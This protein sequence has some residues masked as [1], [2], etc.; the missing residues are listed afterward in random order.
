MIIHYWHV[1]PFSIIL[2][3]FWVLNAT[4]STA[5]KPRDTQDKAMY[6][7]RL[8]H[9]QKTE[10][11]T[12][13]FV[14][15]VQYRLLHSMTRLKHPLPTSFPLGFFRKLQKVGLP[16]RIAL[17]RILGTSNMDFAT[18]LKFRIGTVL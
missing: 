6:V 16:K 17:T 10:N 12:V 14:F 8:R 13:K 9:R 18:G 7:A 2:L 5:G 15:A 1:L 4:A 11:N 3:S